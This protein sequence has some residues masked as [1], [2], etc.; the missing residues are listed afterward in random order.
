MP[1]RPVP[2]LVPSEPQKRVSKTAFAAMHGQSTA[3]ALTETT[4]DNKRT[5]GHSSKERRAEDDSQ[6]TSA[7]QP[8]LA[9]TPP[10]TRRGVS[11]LDISVPTWKGA[12]L[13]EESQG[14]GGAYTRRKRRK[15]A[16]SPSSF[17]AGSIANLAL[18]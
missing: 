12:A 7:R 4:E 14:S 6:R 8:M 16:A 15:V 10:A 11:G 18:A 3:S 5:C 13:A 1:P 2:P 9:T 17:D